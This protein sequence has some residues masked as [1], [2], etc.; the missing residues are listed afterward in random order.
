MAKGTK[1]Q[2]ELATRLHGGYGMEHS[3][4]GQCR[5]A[6]CRTLHP[7]KGMFGG[8]CHFHIRMVMRWAKKVGFI[9]G[10]PQTAVDKYCAWLRERAKAVA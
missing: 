9:L 10:D 1:E 8:M 6:H 3:R 5:V 4:I 2:I 7:A